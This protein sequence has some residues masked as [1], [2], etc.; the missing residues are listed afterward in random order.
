MGRVKLSHLYT[1][2]FLEHLTGTLPFR[3]YLFF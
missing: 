1:N 2:I 3:N